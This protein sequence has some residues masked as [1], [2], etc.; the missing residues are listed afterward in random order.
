MLYVIIPSFLLIVI[1]VYFI[2]HQK[3]L[4]ENAYLI[5]EAVRNRDFSFRLS[6]K[7]FF[8]GERALMDALG[9]L[10]LQV[11]KLVAE[12]EVESWRRLTRVLTHEIM[13]ST[14]PITSITQAYLSMPEIKG[15]PYEEGMQT[16]HDTS[17]GLSLFV[18]NYRKFT[19]LQ[20]AVPTDV[21]LCEMV[22]NIG[23]LFPDQK[24]SINI[25]PDIHICTDEGLLRQ[26]II[27]LAKNAIEAS[28]TSVDVRWEAIAVKDEKC[29]KRGYL[30][31]SNNGNP[32]PAEVAREIFVP[33]FTTKT[34]G[35][36]IGLSL[37]RQ[38]M[39]MQGGN[40]TLADRPVSGY[41][42]TFIIGPLPLA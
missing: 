42:T 21:K 11:S 39:V 24:W 31:I 30:W 32:I 38:I 40:L 13:N 34:S 20:K 23:V 27:N 36:G 19:Q 22:N 14:A 29:E 35:T 37:S 17:R 8:F 7:G 33:F 18:D 16:I 3:K 10:S 25:N 1:A 12:N 15:T 2:Y 41:H 28:S 5:R 26:T 9:D 6:S 4:E